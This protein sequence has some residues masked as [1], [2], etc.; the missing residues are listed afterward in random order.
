M[1]I[2]SYN[3]LFYRLRQEFGIIKKIEN[4]SVEQNTTISQK[5]IAS[6]ID[7]N[8]SES[9]TVQ[10]E[11]VCSVNNCECPRCKNMN[12]NDIYKQ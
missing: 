1:N 2:L 5:P 7:K 12:G 4:K 9:E 11:F 3:G 10:N 6:T 8:A